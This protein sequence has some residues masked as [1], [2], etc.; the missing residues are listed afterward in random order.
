MYTIAI[1]AQTFK[2]FVDKITELAATLTLGK[3][4]QAEVKELVAPKIQ[5]AEAAKSSIVQE[6]APEPEVVLDETK[7]DLAMVKAALQAVVSKNGG[8]KPGMAAAKK[9]LQEAGGAE[10]LSKLEESN[11]AAVVIAAKAAVA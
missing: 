1:E 5:P 2:E 4:P 8:G 3:L 10:M 6:P 11:F 9:I 7:A